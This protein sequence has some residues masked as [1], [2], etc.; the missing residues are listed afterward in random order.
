MALYRDCAGCAEG[1][2]DRHRHVIW[3]SQVDGNF[4][5]CGGD[6][7][8]R[9]DERDRRRAEVLQ[10]ELIGQVLDA[11]DLLQRQGFEVVVGPCSTSLDLSG[12]G[13][14]PLHLLQQHPSLM[15]RR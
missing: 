5:N 14:I 12:L 2:H 11:I 10:I 7:G 15:A 4:C 8:D 3:R 13:Q 9:K 1:N 6:C